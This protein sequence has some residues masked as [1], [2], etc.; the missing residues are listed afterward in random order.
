MSPEMIK[1]NCPSCGGQLN[2]PNDLEIA[3]CTFC[4]TKV[5]LNTTETAHEKQKLERY[6]EL[7]DIAVKANNQKEVIEYCNR[8]LEN[9]PSDVDSWIDKA[10]AVCGISTESNDGWQEATE[11]LRTAKKLAPND[12]IIKKNIQ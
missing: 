5:I 3:F 9:D 12:E 4:G 8:I 11:Y 10:V 2:L 6:R 7:R 1:L